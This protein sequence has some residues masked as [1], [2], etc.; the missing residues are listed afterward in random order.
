MK[1]PKIACF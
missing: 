1:F